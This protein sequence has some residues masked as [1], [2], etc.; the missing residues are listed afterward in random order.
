MSTR[1]HPQQGQRWCG[2]LVQG[3]ALVQVRAE[4]SLRVSTLDR[5]DQWTNWTGSFHERTHA[6]VHVSAGGRGC[7]P[8]LVRRSSPS[9]KKKEGS[10]P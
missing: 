3:V 2:P 4:K 1:A 7:G 8:V 5:V 6:H 9:L 10:A